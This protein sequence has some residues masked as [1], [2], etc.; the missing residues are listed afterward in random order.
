M[1]P[2]IIKSTIVLTMAFLSLFSYA[3]EQNTKIENSTYVENEFII[4]LEQDVNASTFAANADV[5]IVPKRQLSKR[6]NIWLFEITD[7]KEPR[8]EKISRL[9]KNS[10]VRVIQ[11]NHTNIILREAIPD[12]PYYSMQWAPAIMSLPQAW[13]EFT[14][15]GVTATGDTIVV[16]VIDGGADWTHEDLNCWINTQ[17]IPNNGIDD[18]GNGYIDDYHGWN[19]YNHNGYVSSSNHGTHVSGI[20]GAVG[21][22][23]KGVC[24]VNWNV[25][26]LPI[27]GSSGNE[28]IVVEAYSYALEMR[29]RYNETNGEEGAFIVSTNSSFGVDYGNPDDYPIWCSMYDEMGNVGILSCGAGPNMNVNVDVVG[30]VPSACPGDYLIG[31]TNTNSSD[32]KYG[33]AGYG[34]ESIDIGAP[35]TSIYSTTPNNN[36]G[37]MT[38]TSMATPQVSGTIALMYAAMPEEMMQACKSDPAN[39]CLSIKQSLFDGADQLPSLDGLVAGGRRLNAYGAIENLLNDVTTPTLIGEVKIDGEPVFGRTLTAITDLGS[40]PSIPDLGELTYQ[41]RRDTTTIEGAVFQTYTLTEDDIDESI[42]VQVSAA[43]CIGIVVSPFVGPI[44]KAEQAMPEAPQMES[45]TETSITLVAIEGCEYN[46]DGG[47]WQDSPIFEGLT[48]STSYTFTQRKKETRSYYA[49]PASPETVFCTMPLTRLCENHRST[50]KIYPNPA[51]G[52]VIA[53][54]TGTMTVTN[55]LGQTILTKEIKG[56]EKFE[57]PQG[58]YFVTLGDETRKIIV[59]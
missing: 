58:M 21:D 6:L 27:C 50:F 9:T 24:G 10:N 14:T 37:N 22:N 15:G 30:D 2:S 55:A 1:K 36:Y 23:G 41:W 57:L 17:E 3:Q 16:A 52:Y 48:P 45:N 13:E 33:S 44:K 12:D 28:S 38:G 19:A 46:I 43:N 51:K 31:I 7:S 5:G 4:W 29:A 8:A 35:G 18:D 54:G 34:I 42:C 56:K 26:V 40:I 32:E 49:S 11:N 20:I 47:E 39:F 25:K 59:E 53:E